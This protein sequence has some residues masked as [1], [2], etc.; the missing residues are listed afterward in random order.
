[1]SWNPLTGGGGGGGNDSGGGGGSSSDGGDDLDDGSDEATGQEALR[2][3]QF[4]GGASSNSSGGGGGGGGGGGSNPIDDIVRGGVTGDRDTNIIDEVIGGSSSDSSSSD[5]SGSSSSSGSSGGSS[6]GG[7]SSQDTRRDPTLER[8]GEQQTSSD[9]QPTP[10]DQRD[11]TLQ[12]AADQQGSDTSSSEGNSSTPEPPQSDSPQSGSSPGTQPAPDDQRDPALE[13]AAEQSSENDTEAPEAPPSTPDDQRDPALERVAEQSSVESESGQ[14][15]PRAEKTVEVAGTEVGASGAGIEASF[16]PDQGETQRRDGVGVGVERGP[17]IDASISSTDNLQEGERAN[18]GL[19][20]RNPAN[21][22]GESEVVISSDGEVL[23]RLTVQLDAGE[24]RTI[25]VGNIDAGAGDVITVR[26]GGEVVDTFRPSSGPAN[27]DPRGLADEAGARGD[28]RAARAREVEQQALEEVGLEDPEAVD[29]VVQENDTET[30]FEAEL[31]EAGRDQL[32]DRRQEQE[33]LIDDAQREQLANAD[34]DLFQAAAEQRAEQIADLNRQDRTL[35]EAEEAARREEAR[36]LANAD[37]DLFE[38]AQEQRRE[39][40]EDATPTQ[41]LQQARSDVEQVNISG[42][43]G[44]DET[45]RDVASAGLSFISDDPSLTAGPLDLTEEE[46]EARTGGGIDTPGPAL[47]PSRETRA[48]TFAT[49]GVG[50]VPAFAADIANP[51]QNAIRS[52]DSDEADR[53]VLDSLTEGR[54]LFASGT[55]ELNEPD[56]FV[57]DPFLSGEVADRSDREIRQEVAAATPGVDP[58]DVTVERDGD[59]VQFNADLDTQDLRE[60]VAAENPGV[61]ADE[62]RVRGE[63]G[64]PRFVTRT[65]EGG[66]FTP[67]EAELRDRVDA[68]QQALGFGEEVE[69]AVSGPLAG[70]PGGEQA[71]GFAGGLGSA[72]GTAASLPAQALLT[73]DTAV[74]AG[75]NGPTP[76]ASSAPR[77]R[78]RQSASPA[79]SRH[80]ASAH[81]PLRILDGSPAS[82]PAR[83]HSASAPRERSGRSRTGREPHR[84]GPVAAKCSTPRTCLTHPRGP[85]A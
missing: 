65:N 35:F 54:G 57:V 33:P 41:T 64:D 66:F 48:A 78:P 77:R 12:R 15:Q 8:A 85:R 47:N 5:S 60:R 43:P 58:S 1:M 9:T 25:D 49:G 45:A 30:Q 3:G 39:N 7:S 74:E 18:V 69:G 2:Q 76:W 37:R 71:A 53:E 79:V 31:T 11:P 42:R 16:D 20:V 10:D 68:R 56:E 73:A 17:N 21:D 80:S 13:R 34:R 38:A 24:V 55:R 59:E 61:S 52:G 14:D 32:R 83:P 27:T 28:R 82:S 84:S 40:I 63:E 67:T 72:P 70:A 29:V 19:Q 4:S 62:V 23:D 51:N 50:F 75:S 36:Q 46:I 22:G 81:R 6:S 26:E 44:L